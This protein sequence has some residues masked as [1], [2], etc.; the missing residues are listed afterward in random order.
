MSRRWFA[1]A[2]AALCL[3]LAGCGAKQSA[4]LSG[5]V[6]NDLSQMSGNMVYSYVYSMLRE[7][8]EYV[9]Q[10]FRIRGVYQPMIGS[11][12]GQSRHYIFI[13]DAAACCAEGLEFVL[14]D[15]D[16][17]YPEEGAQIEIIGMYAFYEDEEGFEFVR[18]EATSLTTP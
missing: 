12:T 13:A 15:A 5:T 3:F 4:D 6:M 1:A 8:E 18:I 17:A 2:L 16:A 10:V 9:G 7:P 14:L 11:I